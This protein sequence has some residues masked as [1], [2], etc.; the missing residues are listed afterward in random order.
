MEKKTLKNRV[1]DAVKWCGENKEVLVVAIPLAVAGITAITKL[2]GKLIG[3]YNERVLQD[4][5][6]YDHGFGTYWKLRRAL[7]NNDR[8]T[9]ERR[10]A[11][12]EKLG[13]ILKDLRLLK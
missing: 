6:I 10:R 1:D 2:G 13:D 4:K 12:G 9:I 7:T 5:S 3:T 11:A 8:L